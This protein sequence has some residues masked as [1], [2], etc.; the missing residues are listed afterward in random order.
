MRRIGAALVVGVAIL[1]AGCAGHAD[2][3]RA[4]VGRLVR[5]GGPA[6]GLPAPLPGKI[7]ARDSAGNLHSAAVGRSGRFRLS[8]PPGT[9]TVTGTSPLIQDGKARCS[10]TKPLH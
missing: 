2:S 7:E 5:V 9:Y 8:L 10:A 6:P 1:V 3:G 4:V